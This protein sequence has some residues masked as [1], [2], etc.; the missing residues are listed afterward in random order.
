VAERHRILGNFGYL[1]DY[2]YPLESG[3]RRINRKVILCLVNRQR[4]SGVEV[5][6]VTAATIHFMAGKSILIVDDN[7]VTLKLARLLLAGLGYRVLTAAT[8]EEAWEILR[9]NRPDL[10]LTDIQLPGM[11]GLELT[12]RIKSHAETRDIRVVALAAFANS[13]EEAEAL[14]AGCEG[15][16]PKPVD[17]HTLGSR[18]REF[19]GV[20]PLDA[21]DASASHPV[22]DTELRPL[23]SRFLRQALAHIH[24]WEGELEGEFEPASAAQEVHQWIGAAGLLG[25]PELSEKAR[26]LSASLRTAPIDTAEL[27]EIL[28]SL[29]LALTDRLEEA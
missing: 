18:V 23:Q 27:R 7:V 9:S 1:Y 5:A 11:N 29:A 19:L 13:S 20:V 10:V 2:E 26:S 25:Y 6:A 21:P 4:Y 14:R 22:S 12:S 16:I 24:R 3:N 17:A 15:F 28:A 8:A